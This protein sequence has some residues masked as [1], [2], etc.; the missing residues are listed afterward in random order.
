MLF[1]LS[2]DPTS[3]GQQIQT[4]ILMEL[5]TLIPWASIIPISEALSAYKYDNQFGII[6]H[7]N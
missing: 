3:Y 6:F 2:N 1:A 7:M 4:K 5:T